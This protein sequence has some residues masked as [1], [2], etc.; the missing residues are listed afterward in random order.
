MDATFPFGRSGV[1]RQLLYM[2]VET[3]DGERYIPFCCFMS[4]KTED[5]YDD[6]FA[7]ITSVAKIETR[8]LV[9]GIQ[10]FNWLIDL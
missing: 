10:T 3:F 6:M 1:F 9:T 4:Q 5:S 8:F 2:V 7:Y